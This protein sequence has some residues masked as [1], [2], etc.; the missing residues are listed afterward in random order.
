MPVELHRPC[1]A[2]SHGGSPWAYARPSVTHPGIRSRQRVLRPSFV[3]WG[4]DPTHDVINPFHRYPCDHA[5]A[6]I[7]AF[8][9][10]NGL[11]TRL[12]KPSESTPLGPTAAP[13]PSPMCQNRRWRGRGRD[14]GDR[15]FEKESYTHLYTFA[16][17]KS[18]TYSFAT[19]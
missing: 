19:L 4:K 18:H 12:T 17:K 15:T 5:A 2:P 3:R 13:A 1:A 7:F 6:Q 8:V 10:S 11:P 16:K 9:T 14:S